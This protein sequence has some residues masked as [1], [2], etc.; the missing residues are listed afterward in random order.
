MRD[1]T[2][3]IFVLV[4][5]LIIFALILFAS[6]MR[7]QKSDFY[8]PYN[9]QDNQEPPAEN[10]NH[11]IEQ[12]EEQIADQFFSITSS[13][14][15]VVVLEILEDSRCREG[16]QCIWAGTVLV[17][18]VVAIEGKAKELTMGLGVPYVFAGKTITM[19]QAGPK[20]AY[21]FKFKIE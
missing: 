9:V 21:D 15:G 10:T 14:N 8:N 11:A 5:I 13:N 6:V 12:N 2:Q 19:I 17:K 7:T 20:G 16:V 4:I 1:N 3:R 18:A